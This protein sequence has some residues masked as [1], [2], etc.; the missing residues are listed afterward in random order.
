MPYPCDK[1]FGT[2]DIEDRVP[3]KFAAC[4]IE[5]LTATLDECDVWLQVTRSARVLQKSDDRMLRVNARIET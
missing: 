5:E 3:V 4:F 2:A 1:R